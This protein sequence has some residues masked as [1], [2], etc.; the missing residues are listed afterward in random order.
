LGLLGMNVLMMT[1]GASATLLVQR[2][3]RQRAGVERA[4]S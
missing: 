2:R 3:L 1:L 4:G